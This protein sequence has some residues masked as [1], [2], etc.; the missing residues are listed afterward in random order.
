MRFAVDAGGRRHRRSAD[1]SRSYGGV[2]LC[3]APNP[4]I[5][6][7]FVV[8]DLQPGAIH[9]PVSFVQ[10]PG[11]KGLNVA[12]AA[13]ILGAEVHAVALLGGHHGRWIAAE[14]EALG[15]PFTAVWHDGETRSCLSVADADSGSLT[16]F[17]EE[18]SPV[19]A[20]VWQELVER[21]RELGVR[22]GWVTV[23]GSLPPGAPVDGYTQFVVGRSVAVDSVQLGEARPA[24]VKVNAA[25]AAGLTGREDVVAAARDLRERAGGEGHAAIVTRGGTGAV[26]VD[27]DGGEWQG[28]LELSGSYPVGS[29]DAFLA[30]LVVALEGGWSWPDA[31][32]AALG[33]GAANAEVPGAGR[34]DRSRAEALA[35]SARVWSA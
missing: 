13:S 9:R 14:V 26:L 24:L 10:V 20:T 23:S 25:E 3:V 2:I 1:P 27:P 33:A 11:G 35:E 16:E 19:N 12:R 32:R 18:G 8:E 15:F 7:L 34:L 28:Q 5:D 4:S 6:K 21:V 30:G 22:A 31:L 29:G 17:Y